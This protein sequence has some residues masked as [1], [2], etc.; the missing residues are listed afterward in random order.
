MGSPAQQNH[1]G[2]WKNTRKGCKSRAVRLWFTR[3]SNVSSF[4]LLVHRIAVF[5]L[6]FFWVSPKTVILLTLVIYECCL[7]LIFIALLS[8]SNSFQDSCFP[9][10]A[11]F[12]IG[13]QTMGRYYDHM[14]S[15]YPRRP[16]RY[17]M[18]I[19]CTCKVWNSDLTLFANIARNKLSSSE[20]IKFV[21]SGH[22]KDVL[23][24]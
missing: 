6:L 13:C 8:F 1:A 9:P 16:P 18:C 20:Q 7:A 23:F 12:L 10:S 17:D 5:V 2:F 3:F 15:W 19:N 22:K 24:S 4:L 11:R 21:T 14:E